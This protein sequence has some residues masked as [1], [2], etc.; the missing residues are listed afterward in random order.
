MEEAKKREAELEIQRKENAA[1]E[2]EAALKRESE[3]LDGEL[4]QRLAHE[5]KDVVL[6]GN[7]KELRA[8]GENDLSKYTHSELREMMNNATGTFLKLNID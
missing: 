1:K 5:N 7:Q 8:V 3:R 2:A 4:A 6:E